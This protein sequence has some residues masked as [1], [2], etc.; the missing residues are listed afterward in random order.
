MAQPSRKKIAVYAYARDNLAGGRHN[1]WSRQMR[2]S[3][4]GHVLSDRNRI[5]SSSYV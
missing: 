3:R 1:A 2:H 4:L 5:Y